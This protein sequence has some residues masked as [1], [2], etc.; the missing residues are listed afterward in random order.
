MYLLL[1]FVL[2]F[3]LTKISLPFI[4]KLLLGAGT[5]KENFRKETVPAALG[6]VFPL[7]FPIVLLVFQSLKYFGLS[8][9][10]KSGEFYAFLFF[11]TGLG[12]LGLADDILKDDQEKG[13]RQ[14]LKRLWQGKLTSGGLKAVFGFL[15]S[16]IFAIGIWITTGE[17]WWLLVPRILVGALSPNILN[18]FDLRPGRAIKVLLFGFF[19]LF[20]TSLIKSGLNP[21]LYLI[22]SIIGGVLAYFP[23]DLQA[24]GMLGDTGA[25]FL[26]GVFGGIVVLDGS[27]DLLLIVLMVLIILQI[28]AEKV[29]FTKIIEENKFL[30]F[31]DDLGRK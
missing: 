8:Q 1:L 13:F 2:G 4:Y 17:A 30:K 9:V 19:L 27:I 6:L 16:I 20:I 14:H 15:F 29:S 18:L 22:A 3:I 12:L 23:L 10:L 7:T 21:M 28:I 24:R 25:N 5:V 31:I 11:I 26:G